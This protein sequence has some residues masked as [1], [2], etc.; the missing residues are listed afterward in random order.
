MNAPLVVGVDEASRMLGV[1]STQVRQWIDAGLLPTVK[2][3]S[4]RRLG[5]DARRVLI[6]VDD[7]AAFVQRHRER[8]VHAEVNLR[9]PGGV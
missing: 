8:P 2:F 1:G 7:L 6:A 4:I 9:R 5:E 3:P